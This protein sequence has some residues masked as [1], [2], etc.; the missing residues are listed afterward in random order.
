MVLCSIHATKITV[1]VL[2][3]GW[4]KRC[5]CRTRRQYDTR[6]ALT[7]Y[8]IGHRIKRHIRGT[9]LQQR[10]TSQPKNKNTWHMYTAVYTLASDGH[11]GR[12]RVRNP[13]PLYFFPCFMF[14]FLCFPFFLSTRPWRLCALLECLFIRAKRVSNCYMQE[15]KN[16]PSVCLSVLTFG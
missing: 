4:W 12:S 15:K 7:R 16:W 2:S 1:D 6:Y 3:V 11:V 14:S 8:N 10:A 9:C 5:C 13:A